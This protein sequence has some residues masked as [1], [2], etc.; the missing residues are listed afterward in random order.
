VSACSSRWP[1]AGKPSAALA[2]RFIGWAMAGWSYNDRDPARRLR[3]ALP[4]DRCADSI[5]WA[6]S[7]C[8]GPR[9]TLASL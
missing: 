5:V 1:A 6:D 3:H 4:R 9:R 2:G 7:R 8:K